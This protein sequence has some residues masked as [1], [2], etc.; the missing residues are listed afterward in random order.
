MRYMVNLASRLLIICAVAGLCLAV[1]YGFTNPEIQKHK[2]EAEMEAFEALFPDISTFEEVSFDEQAYDRVT[3]VV[4]ILNA[5]GDVVG[6]SV[7]VNAKGYKGDISLNVGF[8]PNGLLSG[9]RVGSNSETAGLGSKVGEPD[10][11]RQYD[12]KT[13]PLALGSDIVAITGATIS[14]RAVLNGVNL[15]AEAFMSLG[16]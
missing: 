12:N 3:K 2:A 5:G 4:K 6:Y 11:Y 10:Y 7:V 14:S 15:A 8:Y 16:E 13:P 1:T 9:I